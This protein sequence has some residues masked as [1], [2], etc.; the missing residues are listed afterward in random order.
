[1]KVRIDYTVTV[2][3]SMRRIIGKGEM[4]NEKDVRVWFMKWGST[5]DWEL[6]RDVKE[7]DGD[8]HSPE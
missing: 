5:R 4:A 2:T 8:E 3:D 6:F 7:D 1:M